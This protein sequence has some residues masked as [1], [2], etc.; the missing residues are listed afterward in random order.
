MSFGSGCG[1]WGWGDEKVNMNSKP[2]YSFLDLD[3]YKNT[4][5]A[6]ITVH[7]KVVPSLPEEEKFDLKP[8]MRRSSKAI[9]ALIAE[10]YA[11]KNHKKSW[12]KYLE[13]A[14]GECN[15][16]ITHL[17]FAKDLYQKNVDCQLCQE[18]IETYNIAGKQIY[19]LGQRW[20][21]RN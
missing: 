12:K 5:Q 15:E 14:I 1:L 8:Q 17:S 21:D 20:S 9:P 16:M 6:S 11:K 4:Y 3:I 10:G 13:D 2:A 7:L 18:L 19:T